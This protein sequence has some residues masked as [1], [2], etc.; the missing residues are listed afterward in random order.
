MRVTAPDRTAVVVV[1]Y[2]PSWP[3]TFSTQAQ[4]VRAALGPV[5]VQ[6]GH[7]GS[8]AVPGLPAKAVID[9]AVVV[10]DPADEDSYCPALADCGYRLVVREP[11]WFQHRML[12]RSVPTVN[13]HVYPVECP[14]VENLVRF[15]DW[16]RDHDDDRHLYASVKSRLAQKSWSTVRQYA[17]AK[18]PIIQAIMARAAGDATASG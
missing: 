15:R 16:L 7:V 3:E 14:E 12:Q 11:T 17:D 6:V 18:G 4:Q 9:M 2:D 5:A 13:L 8:T 1:P 10:A